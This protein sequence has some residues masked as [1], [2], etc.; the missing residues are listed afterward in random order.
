MKILFVVSEVEDLA[1]TGGLADVAKSLPIALTEMGHEVRIVKPYYK[2][3]AEKYQLDDICPRQQ[4][5]ANHKA[6][7]FGIKQ[8]ELEKVPVYCMTTRSIST[9]TA[10]IQTVTSLRRQ[11]RAFCFFS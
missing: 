5:H 4:L 7:P 3:L 2:S 9:A 11:C 8:L 1:K 6:Y 10:F